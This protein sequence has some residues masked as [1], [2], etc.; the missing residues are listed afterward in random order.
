M[1]AAAAATFLIPVGTDTRIES[2]SRSDIVQSLY[3]SALD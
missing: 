3:I 1:A 2:S